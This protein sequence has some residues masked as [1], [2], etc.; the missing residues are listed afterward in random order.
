VFY[1]TEH[2]K[3]MATGR[4]RVDRLM[5]NVVGI[6]SQLVGTCLDVI[7]HQTSRH[8][9]KRVFGTIVVAN[10]EWKPLS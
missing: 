5:A 4:L 6:L 10:S 8:L 7:V 9:R 2:P 1:E 3:R